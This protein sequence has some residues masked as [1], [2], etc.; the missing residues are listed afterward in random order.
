MGIWIDKVTV[1]CEAE[2]CDNK[3]DV[4]KVLSKEYSIGFV[5]ISQPY[6]KLLKHDVNIII[7]EENAYSD[8][9]EDT[10]MILLYQYNNNL[11]H[12]L[13]DGNMIVTLG[14]LIKNKLFNKYYN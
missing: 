10:R 5:L 12:V 2:C 7:D 9:E 13:K 14:K 6:S 3:K 11:I 4:L 1:F 8:N